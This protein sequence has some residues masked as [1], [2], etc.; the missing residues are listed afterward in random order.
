MVQA[1]VCH[2]GHNTTTVLMYRGLVLLRPT[3]HLKHADESLF[4]RHSACV[5]VSFS[6]TQQQCCIAGNPVTALNA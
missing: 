3:C 5:S 6:A 2:K 4:S 1:S